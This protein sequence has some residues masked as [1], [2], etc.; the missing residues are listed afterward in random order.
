MTSSEGSLSKGMYMN[1]PSKNDISKI[2]HKARIHRSAARPQAWLSGHLAKS[3]L[4][5]V[6]YTSTSQRK[7]Q[8][9]ISDG[10]GYAG[11]RT[12][13][14]GGSGSSCRAG[15][16]RH[17]YLPATDGQQSLRWRYRRHSPGIVVRPHGGGEE[18]ADRGQSHD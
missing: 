12:L 18:L 17:S 15:R 4:E 7:I 5:R 3:H 14:G 1:A 6:P 2:C 16:N 13:P 9:S 10:S 8:L 11:V